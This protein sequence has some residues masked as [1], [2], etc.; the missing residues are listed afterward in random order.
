MKTKPQP[1]LTRER[2]ACPCCG[3]D[4][5][6]PR[7][8]TKVQAIESETGVKLTITS[9]CRCKAHNKKVGG[10]ETSSHLKG[11]AVDIAC[12]RSRT[13]HYIIATAIRLGFTRIGIGKTFIHLDLDQQKSAEVIWLY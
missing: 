8:A 5:I 4:W 6:D 3:E 9:G 10:S 11:L 7:V 12:E 1:Q 13:R 2:F